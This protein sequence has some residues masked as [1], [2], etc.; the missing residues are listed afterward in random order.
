MIINFALQII[1]LLISGLNLGC[2]D[3]WTLGDKVRHHRISKFLL[4]LLHLHFVDKILVKSSGQYFRMMRLFDSFY[5]FFRLHEVFGPIDHFLSLC[6]NWWL[7]GFQVVFREVNLEAG[8]CFSSNLLK[9]CLSFWRTPYNWLFP[10]LSEII[11][12]LNWVLG[13]LLC[14]RW[15]FYGIDS[16]RVL[17]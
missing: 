15:Q 13:H 11:D 17:S 10:H 3:A 16:H 2:A 14:I 4:F 8:V 9:Y 12:V 6:C 1:L 5:S 7:F